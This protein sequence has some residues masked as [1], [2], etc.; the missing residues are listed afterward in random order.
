[1]ADDH[2]RSSVLDVR[3]PPRTPCIDRRGLVRRTLLCGARPS[4]DQLALK[5][6][7]VWS[8]HP[9]ALLALDSI[10]S[11]REHARGV[12]GRVRAERRPETLVAALVLVDEPAHAIVVVVR[13]RARY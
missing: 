11:R 12:R 4:D 9:V 13:R 3:E 6:V 5:R 8:E 1:M 10:P 7:H 2:V